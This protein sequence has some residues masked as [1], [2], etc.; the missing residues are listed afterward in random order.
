MRL[1][2]AT[3][4]RGLECYK[5]SAQDQEI[6]LLKCPICHKTVCEDCILRRSGSNFCSRSCADFFFFGD[7]D[8]EES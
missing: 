2:P 7:D 4:D 5:C 8:E 1:F 6:L 3:E